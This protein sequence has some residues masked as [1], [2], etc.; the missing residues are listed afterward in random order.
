V[1]GANGTYTVQINSGTGTRPI[2]HEISYAPT[3]S[4]TQGVTTLPV[5][6]GSSVSI[7]APGNSAVFRLRSSYD[8]KTWSSYQMASTQ[9]VSAGL[10]E[11]SAISAGGAFNQT[12][13][14]VVSSS[15][16]GA[17][18]V[19]NIHGT[20]G[21]FSSYTAV[22]GGVQSLRPSA[23]LFGLVQQSKQFV[24]WDGSQYQL[25]PNLASALADHLEPVGLVTVG[26]A[27]P[28]G[29][30]ATGGNGG[31]LTAV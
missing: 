30:T 14:A 11:S 19:V 27:T 3:V 7:P 5:T 13:Y 2:Y 4:F 10:V 18:D 20:G 25:Q 26:S 8:Q 17:G 12:N 22:K 29:G 31:R 6:T 1:A 16:T 15:S 23:T 28:G 21:Q 24:A 9:P